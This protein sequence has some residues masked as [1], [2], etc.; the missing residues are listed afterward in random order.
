M[1]ER[2]AVRVLVVDDQIIVREGFSVVLA[3]QPGIEIVGAAADGRE[4][5]VKVDELRPDV[6][7]MDVRMP[8]MDGL[9]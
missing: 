7:L 9:E 6:V 2:P 3:A 4:A 5:L 8:E 1:S